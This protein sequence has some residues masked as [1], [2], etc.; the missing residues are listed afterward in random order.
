VVE[1]RHHT[2]LL[3]LVGILRCV[4]FVPDQIPRVPQNMHARA[5]HRCHR[6]FKDPEWLPL[7]LWKHKWHGGCEDPVNLDH[8]L[9]RTAESRKALAFTLPV[10]SSFP[11][12]HNV[13]NV[14]R[15]QNPASLTNRQGVRVRFRFQASRVAGRDWGLKES[16]RPFLRIFLNFRVCLQGYWW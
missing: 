13:R 12:C 10:W 14:L 16:R 9:P 6:V 7:R 11:E 4:H 3:E 5:C 8:L 2:L 15:V 1:L